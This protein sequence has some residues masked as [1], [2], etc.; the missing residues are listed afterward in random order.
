MLTLEQAIT[1][2]QNAAPNHKP[3]RLQLSNPERGRL[4][5]L[6]GVPLAAADYLGVPVNVIGLAPGNM[7]AMQLADGS[8]AK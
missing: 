8:W 3:L 5:S 6:T 7:V 1:Q 4:S 2:I